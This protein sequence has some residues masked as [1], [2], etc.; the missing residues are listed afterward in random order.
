[1]D[2]SRLPSWTRTKLTV[3][4]TKPLQRTIQPT[5]DSTRLNNFFSDWPIIKLNPE[6]LI[7]HMSSK[8]RQSTMVLEWVYLL[9]LED[10]G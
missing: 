4:D 6:H 3:S 2:V 8:A 7:S 9:P 10:L 5:P 1:M